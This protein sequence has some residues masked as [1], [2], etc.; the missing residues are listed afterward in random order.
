MKV[1]ACP[2]IHWK[3]TNSYN[4]NILDLSNLVITISAGYHY[5]EE[6]MKYIAS[7]LLDTND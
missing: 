6:N 2:A 5:W 7:I 3:Q 4:K 1:G